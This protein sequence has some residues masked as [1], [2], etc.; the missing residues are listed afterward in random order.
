M[1]EMSSMTSVGIDRSMKAG[2]I[3]EFTKDMATRW[4]QTLLV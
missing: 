3:T 2:I 1:I 4:A